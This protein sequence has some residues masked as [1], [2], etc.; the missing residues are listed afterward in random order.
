MSLKVIGI[1]E[2]LK[3]PAWK[4]RGKEKSS[5]SAINPDCGDGYVKGGGTR[6]AKTVHL[7]AC[8]DK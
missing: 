7:L 8:N 3:S 2:A 1:K 4:I 5:K 6:S